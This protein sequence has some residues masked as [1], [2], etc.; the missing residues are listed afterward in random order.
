MS[1]LK[2]CII[3]AFEN[4]KDNFLDEIKSIIRDNE[5][6]V[7]KNSK[8]LVSGCFHD[9]ECYPFLQFN[10]KMDDYEFRTEFYRSDFNIKGKKVKI[11][12]FEI[13]YDVVDVFFL[14]ED[15]V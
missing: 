10:I 2:M 8:V 5:Y 11:D 14:E 15:L 1:K 13:D 12:E 9:E 7:N 6:P 4:N 3:D